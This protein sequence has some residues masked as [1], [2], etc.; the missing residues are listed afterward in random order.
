MK[1]LIL[2]ALVVILGGLNIYSGELKQ[3]EGKYRLADI[4]NDRAF[5]KWFKNLQLLIVQ[6]QREKVANL[7]HYPLN[8]MIEKREMK[9]RSKKEFLSKY[10]SLITSEVKNVIINQKIKDLTVTSEGVMIGT[11]QMWINVLDDKEGFWITAVNNN[12]EKVT[13]KEDV[14]MK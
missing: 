12:F 7:V 6:N 2:C 5:E 8:I 1:K 4:E 13:S 11:G 9:V 10:N 14:L 3:D